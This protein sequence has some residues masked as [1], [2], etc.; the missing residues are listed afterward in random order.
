[1]ATCGRCGCRFYG[2]TA[3]ATLCSGCEYAALKEEEVRTQ[4]TPFS[5]EWRDQL[6][7]P[8][9]PM[10]RELDVAGIE[11]SAVIDRRSCRVCIQHDGT[12]YTLDEWERVRPLPCAGCSCGEE[13]GVVP[14]PPHCRCTDITH[15]GGRPQP[16]PTREALKR[17]LLAW[18]D[19]PDEPDLI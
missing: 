4:P 10:L 12:F 19:A 3:G 2:E 6:P 15:V 8:D 16:D 13:D 11:V 5:Q 14:D 17:E 9:V 1:M 7:G 18:L